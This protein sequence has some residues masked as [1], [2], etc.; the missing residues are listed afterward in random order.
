MIAVDNA[1]VVGGELVGTECVDGAKDVVG[2]GDAVDVKGAMV[3]V[4]G[5]GV[6][7]AIGVEVE[8]EFVSVVDGTETI[9]K[10]VVVVF[11]GLK[12][13]VWERSACCVGEAVLPCAVAVAVLNRLL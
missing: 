7:V 9:V 1:E 5:A 11:D 13:F 8:V 3:V 10:E 6:D 2:A 12:V 4:N